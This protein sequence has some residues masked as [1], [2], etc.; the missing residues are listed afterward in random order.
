[1]H[2][3]VS[4]H[5]DI[6]ETEFLAHYADR[7]D[8]AIAAGHSFVLGNAQG[9]DTLALRYL[10][11]ALGQEADARVRV[12]FYSAYMQPSDYDIPPAALIPQ[13]FT[14]NAKRDAYLTQISDYDIAWVRSEA[15]SRAL[16][17]DKYRASRVSGTQKN[18]L[19]RAQ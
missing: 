2:A 18:L 6:D 13:T 17:G 11:S 15:A 14:S 8:A 19:R 5:V 10:L 3:F 7:L 16:Y 4:G 9:T 12:A 1:M